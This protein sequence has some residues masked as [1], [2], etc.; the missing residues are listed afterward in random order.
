[1]LE[2]EVFIGRGAEVSHSVVGPETFVGKFTEIRNS[3]AWGRPADQLGA[4]FISAR[5]RRV[6]P[7]LA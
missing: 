2:R 7:L 3:L 1:V 6:S 4:G 5:A